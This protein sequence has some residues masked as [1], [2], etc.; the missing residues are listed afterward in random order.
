MVA[1]SNLATTQA[2]L[3]LMCINAPN[4]ILLIMII[5]VMRMVINT[6]LL[7]GSKISAGSMQ[8]GMLLREAAGL[9]SFPRLLALTHTTIL[10]SSTGLS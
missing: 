4:I 7:A 8:S 2:C 3:K 5:M 10:E 1:A 9:Y 6:S